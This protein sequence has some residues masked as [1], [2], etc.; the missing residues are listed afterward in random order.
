MSKHPTDPRL[1]DPG[2]DRLMRSM[3]APAIAF[4]I[5]WTRPDAD[6][7]LVIVP[8]PDAVFEDLARQAKRPYV[9]IIAL[10]EVWMQTL[11][12]AGAIPGDIP[13]GG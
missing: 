11:L 13:N 4:P 10:Y 8:I 7:R 3:G 2:F 6:G 9:E 5:T 12:D 1:T